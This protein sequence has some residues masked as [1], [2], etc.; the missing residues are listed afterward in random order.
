MAIF[1]LYSKRKARQERSGKVDVYQ[2]DALPQKFR[3]QV[4]H[5]LDEAL[6]PYSEWGRDNSESGKP[7]ILLH[8]VLCEE[9]GVFYLTEQYMGKKEDCLN[10]LLGTAS[11][12]DQILDLIELSFR[13]LASWHNI[14]GQKRTSKVAIADLN[15]RFLE[16]GIG[17]QFENGVLIRM[18][19]QFIHAEVTKA[20]LTL[21][22]Q[23]GFE[24]VED[25]FRKAHLHYR[26]GKNKE[27]M[28]EALKAFE[29]T[30]KTICD[31]RKWKYP[32]NATAKGLLDVIFDNELIPK[33]LVA[34]F[35]ALRSTLEAGVPTLRN[36]QSGHGQ[37]QEVVEVPSYLAAYTLH[38][39]ASAIVLLVEAE[40]A[41]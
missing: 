2:Y 33:E 10:F 26:E 17:Y 13:L 34:H 19:S 21:V 31:L 4:V 41:N 36:R 8:K 32:P 28:N 5:I 29:S 1:D 14:P 15:T 27:A 6:G 9:Y 3:A 38:L 11:T 24:G 20:T 37:G 22:N 30:A 23:K 16:N 35:S 7:W 25:E 40:K 12:T 39:A 18:D